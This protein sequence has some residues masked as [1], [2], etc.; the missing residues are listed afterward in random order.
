MAKK[1]PVGNNPLKRLNSDSVFASSEKKDTQKQTRPRGRPVQNESW[2]KVTCVLFESQI[3]WLDQLAVDIR[4][5][6]GA[7][8]SRAELIRSMIGAIQEKGFDLTKVT[9][10]EDALNIIKSYFK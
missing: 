4:K 9:S 5:K 2:T 1:R 8:L 6:T 3:T 10:E 7:A